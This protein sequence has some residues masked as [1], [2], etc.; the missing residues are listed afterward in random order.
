[1]RPRIAVI[2]HDSI[3]TTFVHN[4]EQGARDA[5]AILDLRIDWNRHLVDSDSKMTGDIRNAVD[6]GIDGLIVTIP[7]DDVFE[8]VEYALRKNVPVIVFNTGLEYAQRLGLTRVLQDDAEAGQKLASELVRRGYNRPLVI[9]LATL[10]Q[11][12]FESRMNG[13]RAVMRSEPDVLSLPLF[14][15]TLQPIMQIKQAVSSNNTYDSVVSLGGSVAAD[16]TSGAMLNLLQ[17]DSQKR[18]GVAF[19]DLGGMNTTELF[20]RHKD[21]IA[22]SQLPYY[23]TALPVFYMYQRILTGH[24]IYQN[25]TISTG[26]HL[27][28]LD[29]L[30]S[31]IENEQTTLIPLS[32]QNAYV[33]TIIHNARGD[34]YNGALMVGAHDLARKLNWTIL[35]SLEPEPVA[36]SMNLKNEMATFSKHGVNAIILQSSDPSV[37]N[38]GSNISKMNEVPLAKIGDF[39]EPL[40]IG[41][42][43]SSNVALDLAGLADSM[44]SA[45]ATDHVKYPMCLSEHTH[46]HAGTFCGAFYKKFSNLT[47][48]SSPPKHHVVHSLN[49][50]TVESMDAEFQNII[51]GLTARNYTPDAYITISE[52][53]FNII[54]TRKQK[55]YMSKDKVLYTSGTLFS[56][57]QAFLEGRIRALWYMDMFSIGFM[58]MMNILLANVIRPHPWAKTIITPQRIKEICPP[59]TFYNQLASSYFCLD[60]SSHTR[61][62]LQCTPCP[63]NTYTPLSNQMAC[64]ACDYGTYSPAGS[65]FCTKCSSNNSQNSPNCAAYVVEQSEAHRRVYMAIFLPLGL[66]L[67]LSLLGF[68]VWKVINQWKRRRRLEDET[69]LLS[70][71]DLVRPS[72]KHITSTS[73][74]SRRDAQHVHKAIMSDEAIDRANSSR[75]WSPQPDYRIASEPEL[76]LKADAPKMSNYSSKFHEKVCESIHAVGLQLAPQFKFSTTDDYFWLGMAFLHRSK[77]LYHGCLTSKTCM[78]SGKWE[79]KITDYG[80]KKVRHSQLDPLIQLSLHKNY[81]QS[82]VQSNGASATEQSEAQALPNHEK[83]L[84]I[85]PESVTYSPLDV[86]LTHPSKAADVYSAGIIINEILTRETPYHELTEQGLSPEVIF[87]HI[88]DKGLRP[89]MQLPMQDEYSDDVN[90]VI[91]DCLQVDPSLRPTFSGI[92]LEKYANDMENL[93]RKRTANLQQR[94]LELEEERARTQTLLKD[95]KAAKEVAEAAAASK[96]NFL[97]NMSHEI[98]TPLNAVIGMSRMLMESDLSPDLYECAE[99]IESSGNHL[100]ALIDDI[101]DFSKIESGK[102][103]LERSKLDMTFVVE[104]A[105]KLVSSNF[106]TKGLILWYTIEADVP[107]H[108]YGDLVRL[109]QILLNLLSNAFKFTAKGFVSVHV[110][111]NDT[112]RI[113]EDCQSCFSNDE[114]YQQSAADA[115]AAKNDSRR[116]LDFL[117]SVQDTGIGIP[118]SKVRKLFKSFSQVDAS[119][120]RNFG[121]TGLGLAISR[122]LCRLMEGDMWVKSKYNEG[123]TF[124]FRVRLET[125]EGTQNYGE[126]NKLQALS[127][128]YVQAM[129]IAENP[130]LRT[131]WI[132]LLSNLGFPQVRAMGFEEVTRWFA[133]QRQQKDKANIT[134]LIIDMD[135]EDIQVSNMRLQ[136]SE[137]VLTYLRN[138]VGLASNVI[139]VKDIRYRT[140][141]QLTAKEHDTTMLQCTRQVDQPLCTPQEEKSDPFN[142]TGNSRTAYLTKPLKNSSLITTLHQLMSPTTFETTTRLSRQTTSVNS[143]TKR[144][145]MSLSAVNR[146]GN[147]NG[148]TSSFSEDL[149]KVKAL[150]VDDNPVNQKVLSR[151]LSRMNLSP[152]IANNGKQAFEI[153]QQAHQENN[154]VQLVFM[155]IWMPE[156]NGIEATIKIRQELSGSPTQPYII[157]MTA[158]VMAGDREKCFAAGMNGYVSKPVRKEELEAAIHVYNQTADSSSGSETTLKG[159]S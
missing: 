28:T 9:R 154:P 121:G 81:H 155:D 140:A 76:S 153:I 39:Y 69:W 4:P 15:N 74:W 42:S 119:T 137:D 70:Y 107:I 151:M 125:Q 105:M 158:C 108:V 47:G 26:P 58:S 84:W 31:A 53:I 152:L 5:A 36:P 93:V 120:T 50:S 48:K 111:V 59:G 20:Q 143:R 118:E 100:M 24:N 80:L 37:L 54:D 102:L 139:C 51:D 13:I 91:L 142:D 77:F 71:H 122:K 60:E 55:G 16:I 130:L 44:A 149:S 98:R 56:Q 68:L 157:A 126:Q 136:K 64:R 124:Y 131:A 1:M 6:S 101:L 148:S 25:V 73:S 127:S 156:M 38:Y 96:Q 66:L 135:M 18:I 94:T 61:L 133:Q 17:S 46:H 67:F 11:K 123:S 114:E 14:N 63:N 40:N 87:E 34:T 138:T 129:I 83:L 113:S 134:I 110:Q 8:A 159:R 106:L 116:M 22:V 99:T 43:L 92:G 146:Q 23:Q 104:S 32:E 75:E 109:R 29:N 147:L 86:Y 72:L 7:N 90:A 103:S 27:I 2:S 85:A 12:T 128:H 95:L 145:N 49:I 35:N 141:H 144:S 89:T 82:S 3:V 132:K 65:S 52:Y 62:A 150:L 78:I 41:K 33:G 115:D 21:T 79:L 88:R 97:A 30:Q 10:D 112:C 19:F 117:F 45:A 57:V